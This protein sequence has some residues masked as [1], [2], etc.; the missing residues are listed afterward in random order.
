MRNDTIQILRGIAALSVVFY[1]FNQYLVNVGKNQ[2]SMFNIFDHRFSYGAL[3]FFVISGFLMGK[4]IERGYKKFLLQRL[5]RIYPMYF[6]V[7]ILTILLK[8]LFFGSITQNNFL[9]SLTL[10]PFGEIQYTLG[11]EWTLVYEV[12]FYFICSIFILK[13]IR[14]FFLPFLFIWFIMIIC[15]TYIFHIPVSFLPKIHEILLSSFNI[16]FIAGCFAYYV[17]RNLNLKGKSLDKLV[18]LLLLIVIL[19]LDNIISDFPY[20]FEVHTLSLSLLLFGVIIFGVGIQFRDSVFSRILVR[21]GDFSY[22]LY[23][24]HVP[25]ITIL[26]AFIYLKTGRPVDNFSAFGILVIILILGCYLG[27]MDLN[28]HQMIKQK[29]NSSNPFSLKSYTLKNMRKRV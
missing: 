11:I 15:N 6:I 29:M 19:C 13:R 1:H 16:Y 28:M 25:S 24:T 12:F 2:N 21:I 8:L 26:L 14:K 5:L 3:L 9:E 22:A 23:L 10:L 17:Q 18:V 7:V 20:Y 27:K 4:L